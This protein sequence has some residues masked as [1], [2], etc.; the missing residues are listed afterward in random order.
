[1]ELP[2][3]PIGYLLLSIGVQVA[4][5]RH[6]LADPAMIKARLSDYLDGRE[7]RIAFHDDFGSLPMRYA[8]GSGIVL[9]SAAAIPPVAVEHTAAPPAIAARSVLDEQLWLSK[10][11]CE[12]YLLETAA[13]DTPHFAAS[14][15][16]QQ[17]ASMGAPERIPEPRPR[18]EKGASV[19]AQ[20]APSGSLGFQSASYASL[21]RR[22]PSISSAK[23]TVASVSSRASLACAS[24][25]PNSSLAGRDSAT[26]KRPA[27]SKP[28]AACA[29]AQPGDI[30]HVNNS[31]LHV[32]PAWPT[33]P[34]AGSPSSSLQA[35]RDTPAD[36][37]HTLSSQPIHP[38]KSWR[39]G[40]IILKAAFPIHAQT[41][42]ALVFVRH[43]KPYDVRQAIDFIVNLSPASA[44][45]YMQLAIN[46]STPLPLSAE[47][48]WHGWRVSDHVLPSKM[49][50]AHQT[51]MIEWSHTETAFSIDGKQGMSISSPSATTRL[52]DESVFDGLLLRLLVNVSGL[53][54]P[55]RVHPDDADLTRELLLDSVAAYSE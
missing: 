42:L 8:A 47:P 54:G 13:L 53:H 45:S 28:G 9:P 55:P 39:S 11:A 44:S 15:D 31:M 27:S 24:G 36:A 12:P 5:L 14:A 35:P 21:V 18:R 4:L 16:G 33:Q 10:L 50:S 41:R 29:A 52:Y 26:L 25:C 32:R 46:V 38:H 6:M 2:I 20:Y 23:G 40:R 3:L 17:L 34:A 22:A 49:A 51:F 37:C 43:D 19:S 30:V 48:A 7:R 1:M